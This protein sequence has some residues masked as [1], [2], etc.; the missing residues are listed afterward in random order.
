MKKQSG[1]E[2]YTLDRQFECS[3]VTALCC[4]PKLYSRIGKEII[5][6]ALNQDPAKL[7]M[8]AARA[9]AFDTGN[10][11]D[12]LIIITQ[13]LR[14]WLD[15]GQVTQEEIYS[16][17]DLFDDADDLGLPSDE[18]FID[19]MAPILKQRARDEAVHVAIETLGKRG[20]MTNVQKMLGKAERIGVVDKTIGT[21]IEFFKDE[22][23]VLRNLVRLPTG[24]PELDGALNGGTE[25]GSV[26][27]L[28][29]GAKEGKSMFLNQIAANAWLLGKN[30]AYATLELSK[31]WTFARTVANIT[32]VEIDALLDGQMDSAYKQM[33]DLWSN[34]SPG[35]LRVEKFVPKATTIEDIFEWVER[36]E[37][38]TGKEIHVVIVDYLDKLAVSEKEAKGEYTDMGRISETFRVR[39]E[40]KQKWGWTATQAKRKDKDSKKRI[41]L[42]DVSDSQNK[43][44]VFDG[45]ITLNK[46]DNAILYYIAANR[47]GVDGINV[48]PIP[49]DFACGRIAIVNRNYDQINDSQQELYD[50]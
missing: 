38:E 7:A 15:E 27:C 42:D 8:K 20:D 26:F 13:R 21:E 45:I 30:V 6:D 1:P 5:P 12:S 39:I 49:T 29:G 24:I 43:V 3:L 28:V 48:G 50:N 44:R 35:M 40:E 37:E 31:A 47:N 14:R 23:N 18:H 33:Q 22:I 25:R 19:E 36:I 46:K 4:R 32:G 11:P 10:G 16:V 17:M 34:A 9:I 41:E 2:P